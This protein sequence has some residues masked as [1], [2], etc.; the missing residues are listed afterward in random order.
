MKRSVWLLAFVV[1]IRM[2]S[3]SERIRL[4]E[5]RSAALGRTLPQAIVA[6]AEKTAAAGPAPVLF[7]LHGRG[8]NHRTLLDASS[9]RTTRFHIALPQREDG[10]YIDSPASPEQRYTHYLAEVVARV[11]KKLPVATAAEK[12]GIAGWSMG[13]YGAV[14]FAQTNPGS[15]GFVASVIGLLDFPRAETL[16]QGQNY[17]VPVARLTA[18]PD[19]LARLNPRHVVE[20]LRGSEITAEI[21]EEA[22][23]AILFGNANRLLGESVEDG[24]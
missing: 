15:F 23:R 8:R 3:G 17:R 21:P 20:T 12:H 4:A 22:K 2:A 19:V 7:I 18:D 14:R 9:A 11:E 5:M 24:A 16:P 6:P 1:T 10:W 13:G